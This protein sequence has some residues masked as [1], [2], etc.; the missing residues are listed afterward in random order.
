[1]KEKKKN[2]KRVI[3]AYA[4]NGVNEMPAKKTV[5]KKATA[6]KKCGCCR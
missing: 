2:K 4:I 1:L 6:K 3:F 5:K